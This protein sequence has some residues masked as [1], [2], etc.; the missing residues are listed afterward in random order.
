MRSL[1]NLLA[2]AEQLGAKDLHVQPSPNGLDPFTIVFRDN[3]KLLKKEQLCP[4]E[5]KR[6]WA[7]LQ[8]HSGYLYEK[9]QFFQDRSLFFDEHFLRLAFTPAP[10]L[11]L[12]IRLASEPAL[13]V[14]KL[15]AL[16]QA[17]AR[18]EHHGG[19]IIIAGP[20]HSGKTTLYY[21]CLKHCSTGGATTSSWEDPIERHVTGLHQFL[22]EAGRWPELK[23]AALR[24]DWDI[25]GLGEV[26][27]LS[28]FEPLIF[29]SLSS[30]RT[31]TTMHARSLE[32]LKQKM[33]LLPSIL[34][35]Q[36]RE[37]CFGI[38]FCPTKGAV[39]WHQGSII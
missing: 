20:I 2:L 1:A 21:E 8:F 37:V 23:S 35:E 16:L 17:L 7:Y 15:S 29:L 26:R 33:R 24:F 10:D 34:L 9:S 5:G 14:N 3:R 39:E 19:L 31:L 36:L 30:V 13:L 25:L 38:F 6:L 32:A 4:Q 18:W 22:L 27:D 28:H 11:Y 12:T